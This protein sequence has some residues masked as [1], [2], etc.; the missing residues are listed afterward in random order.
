[1]VVEPT[2]SVTGVPP[3]TGEAV[4][5]YPVMELPPLLA[6]ADQ[7]TVAWALP[8]VAV[9]FCGAHGTLLPVTQVCSEPWM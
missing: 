6:G 3:P 8:A 7:L 1:M 9:T 4:T 2:L 5:V